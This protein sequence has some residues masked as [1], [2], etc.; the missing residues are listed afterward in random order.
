MDVTLDS[1]TANSLL[2]VSN[3]GKQ[4]KN[5]GILQ[6]LPDNPE[7]FDILLGVLGKEGFSSGAFYFE[8]SGL[9]VSKVKFHR[10]DCLDCV[11][12]EHFLCCPKVQVEG[13]VAWDIGIAL[14]TVDRKGNMVVGLRNGYAAL[15][16]RDGKTLKACDQRP[17]E[18]VVSHPL[19]SVG[20]F[21]DH[22]AGEVCFYD[23]GNNAHIYSFTRCQF[24]KKKLHPYLNTC[25]HHEANS[26][27]MVIT[28]AG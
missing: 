8:V 23:V 2:V 17:I 13:K 20:V 15:M 4:V 25:S 10:C 19:K 18:F 1:D 28:S 11:L 26:A 16:L 12:Y 24:P 27:P 5:E 21:V 6:N 22:E 3:D 7:R 14:E 9:S